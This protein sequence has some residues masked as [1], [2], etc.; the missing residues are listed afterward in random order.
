LLIP[1]TKRVSL[2]KLSGNNGPCL[3][4]FIILGELAYIEM[5]D[6]L[7]NFRNQRHSISPSFH[8]FGIASSEADGKP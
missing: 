5:P 6:G 3:L 4:L 8:G 1:E 7:E 2:E